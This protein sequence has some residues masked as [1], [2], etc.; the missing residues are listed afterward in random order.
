MSNALADFSINCS[1]WMLL[2]SYIIMSGTNI[3]ERIKEFRTT[4]KLTQSELAEK[5][6]LTYI[7]I[8]RYET[9]KSATIF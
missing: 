8:G 7:Q 3:G 1:V 2:Y 6:G 4:L 5:V 9:Q